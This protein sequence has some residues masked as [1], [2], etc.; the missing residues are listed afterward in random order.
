M[1]FGRPLGSE[2]GATLRFAG[3]HTSENHFATVHGALLSGWRE[4]DNILE[5]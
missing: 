4:A 2:K 3:E 1:A 5:E